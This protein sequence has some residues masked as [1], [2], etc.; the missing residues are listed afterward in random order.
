M[1]REDLR[2]FEEP[3]VESRVEVDRRFHASIGADVPSASVQVREILNDLEYVTHGIRWWDLPDEERILI[4]D[5]LY[6]CAFAIE[7]N[8]VEAKLH[9]LRPSRTS[10]SSFNSFIK[11]VSPIFQ[12]YNIG[13]DRG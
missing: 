3:Y 10:P 8:L 4:S 11:K 9:I 7:T 6:Q 2:H 13:I 5:Y 12:D 1:R